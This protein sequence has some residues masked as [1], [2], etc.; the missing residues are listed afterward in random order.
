MFCE[1]LSWFRGFGL[2]VTGCLF[3]VAGCGFVVSF[4]Q[5]GWWGE[6]VAVAVCCFLIC[7]VQAL[8]L[9]YAVAVCSF[10]GLKEQI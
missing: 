7:G 9:L 4:L 8:L 1:K 2:H 6:A 10:R 3:R 5:E